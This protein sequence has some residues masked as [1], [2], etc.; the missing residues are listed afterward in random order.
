[1]RIALALPLA[2]ALIGPLAAAP[3]ARA[4][5]RPVPEQAERADIGAWRLA[6]RT[7]PMTDRRSCVL[8][9]KDWIVPP[10]PAGGASTPSATDL[11]GIAFEA[12]DRGGAVVPA[13]TVRDLSPQTLVPGLL[14]LTATVQLRFD[15][16]PVIDMPCGLESR[17]IICAPAA[18]DTQ[19][20]ASELPA[21]NSVL[22][23]FRS[24]LPLPTPGPE[25]PV[26]LDLSETGAA[27]GRLR[28]GSPAETAPAVPG[29]DLRG[30]IEQ[31]LRDWLGRSPSTPSAPAQKS[32]GVSL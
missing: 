28:S 25:E 4:Q 7:D 13:V 29:L 10:K 9:L 20:A 24:T 5:A 22:V 3:P 12:L 31:L 23:R 1:M 21:A 2:A 18:A 32:G 15:G 16:N 8:R 6:C 26:A 14:A 19:R 17:S 30:L 11:P 27:I